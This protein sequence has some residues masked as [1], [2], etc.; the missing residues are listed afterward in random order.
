MEI[1]FSRRLCHACTTFIEMLLTRYFLGVCR[2]CFEHHAT[3]VVTRRSL[4][5]TA[6]CLAFPP[7]I[8]TYTTFMATL[9]RSGPI[10]RRRC[11][12]VRTPPRS[13][14]GIRDYYRVNNLK[15][16]FHLVNPANIIGFLRAAGLFYK[17][18]VE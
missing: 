12:T 3:D 13:E 11:S 7:H 18:C 17:S 2:V 1:P 16:M 14:G 10:F 9:A 5:T 4:A 8:V 6:R 15:E